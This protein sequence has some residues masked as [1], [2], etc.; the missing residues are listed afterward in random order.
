MG[1]VVSS[2]FGS[3]V[4]HFVESLHACWIPLQA[5]VLFT[6]LIEP[7]LRSMMWYVVWY[8]RYVIPLSIFETWVVMITDND[9]HIELQCFQ[10]I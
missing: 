3:V 9:D 6:S 2:F 1:F 10:Q 5:L 4:S 8:R 7:S